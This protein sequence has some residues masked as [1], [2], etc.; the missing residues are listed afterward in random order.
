MIN[1]KLFD[2][3]LT[4]KKRTYHVIANSYL[5]ILN[6]AYPNFIKNYTM[7]NRQ[8]CI[9]SIRFIFVAIF[10][11]LQSIVD[12]RSYYVCGNLKK[13]D[14]IFVSH[15]VNEKQILEGKEL[16]FGSIPDQLL[17]HDID[18]SIVLINHIRVSKKQAC[19]GWKG[20]KIARLIL[21]PS[22]DYI[23]EFRMYLNQIKSKKIL[24]TILKIEGLDRDS[25]RDILRQHLSSQTFNAIRIAKQVSDVVRRT[26][27]SSIIATYEGHAWERLVFFYAR[28]ANPNIKCLGYQHSAVF[29][30]QHA[31]RRPLGGRYD[32]DV[33]FTSGAVSEAILLQSSWKDVDI[34]RLGS[35]KSNSMDLLQLK[36]KRCCLVV[37]Q[38][39]IEECLSLF[40]L[41]M[42]YARNHRDQKF[43]WRLHPL[44]SFDL[45][46]L[47]H[48]AFFDDIPNNVLLS[49][50]ELNDDI[51]E[52]DSVLYRGSTAVIDAISFGLK[53]IY[54][55]QLGEELS[56]DAIYQYDEC[57]A[58]IKDSVELY[59][60][61]NTTLTKEEVLSLKSFSQQFYTPLDLK[62][63]LDNLGDRSL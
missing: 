27:A 22:L 19:S 28:K 51:K 29:Q 52:C 53:P 25:R 37:P 21:S 5:H 44:I 3:V 59:N 6:A 54:Y 43:I 57:K 34:I 32:P 15:L 60:A 13:T 58:I 24:K 50:K 7:T 17:T 12:K 20:S 26:G 1:T 45:L 16:Y 23:S 18:S 41:S 48:K 49:S 9:L 39:E 36:K 62:V 61:L 10:K 4:N 42:L 35:P 55:R 33:I 40:G 14:A 38:G 2:Q 8:K 47:K 30:H 56:T 11:F 63:L 31:I 46:L